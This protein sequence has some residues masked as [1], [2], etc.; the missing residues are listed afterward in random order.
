MELT[1]SGTHHL[2]GGCV[3]ALIRCKCTQ[4]RRVIGELKAETILIQR[5]QRKLMSR[6]RT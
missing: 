3:K 6:I 5:Q 2:A 4:I 1:D